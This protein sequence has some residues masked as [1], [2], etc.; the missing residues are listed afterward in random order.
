MGS[1]GPDSFGSDYSEDDYLEDDYLEEPT[2]RD[3]SRDRARGRDY[4]PDYGRPRRRPASERDTAFNAVVWLL[5][6][7]TGV[8]EE[9]RH[10]D[11]GMSED[12]WLHAYAA[13]R[14]S[15]LALRAVLDEWLG[16]GTEP[17][18]TTE[19]QARAER[20]KRR[21]GIDINF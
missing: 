16:D 6:G 12:F 19:D 11:L 1:V 17:G 14:E 18:A 2:P 8:V 10:N 21:G 13:R 15:L 9:L 3:S 20:R 5:E 7:A 4:Q